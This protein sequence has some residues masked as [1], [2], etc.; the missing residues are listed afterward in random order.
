[1]GN[2][3]EKYIPIRKQ[4]GPEY[5]GIFGGTPDIIYFKI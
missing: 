1:M 5:G 4:E 2:L 3:A